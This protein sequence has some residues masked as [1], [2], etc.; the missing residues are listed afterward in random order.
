M[1]GASTASYPSTAAP[2]TPITGLLLCFHSWRGPFSVPSSSGQ[3]S[4]K[5]IL[6]SPSGLRP[7]PSSWS[8]IENCAA[9]GSSGLIDHSASVRSQLSPATTV[10]R[11]ISTRQ[12][13]AVGGGGL[14]EGGG[15]EG[16]GG[17]GE[18]EGGGGL[19]EGGGGLGDGGGGEGD[20][21]GGLG[22]GGGGE[23]DGGGGDGDGGGGLGEGGGG[24]GE[25]GGG[26]GEGGGG[27]GKDEG[28]G[29]V[30]EVGGG[31]GDGG[32]GDG[33]GGG[34]DGGLSSGGLSNATHVTLQAVS[35][36]GQSTVDSVSRSIAVDS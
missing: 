30:G 21:G 33:D 36:V 27:V 14:G 18:G 2:G 1:Y 29:G 10:W 17:G 32:G 35:S 9:L 13:G 11:E 25:G 28:G 15:G 19:G 22:D 34:G 24:E 26:E 4:S 20:G 7:I 16:D 23:G 31:D 5:R 6:L 8:R 12:T 3:Y